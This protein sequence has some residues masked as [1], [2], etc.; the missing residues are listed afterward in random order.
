LAH[1][2]LLLCVVGGLAAVGGR[3][4]ARVEH[5]GLGRI[6]RGSRTGCEL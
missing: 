5:E 4:S 2:K 1:A 6:P 3:C